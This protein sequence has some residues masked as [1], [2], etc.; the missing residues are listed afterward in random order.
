M[1]NCYVGDIGDFGKYGLLKALAGDDLRLGVAWYLNPDEAR[2]RSE[3]TLTGDG[4]LIKYLIDDKPNLRG[5]DPCLYDKLKNL[6]VDNCD[7]RVA[8]VRERHILS[9][10]TIFYER[11]L[12][13]TGLPAVGQRARQARLEHRSEWLEKALVKTEPCDLVFLDPDNGLGGKSA[14]PHTKAG[15]KFCFISEVGRWVERGQSV[16]VYHHADHQ[17]GGL[18]RLA[19][20]WSLILRQELEPQWVRTLAYHRQ[21]ARLYFILGRGA[22]HRRLQDRLDAFLETSWT[23]YG[24]FTEE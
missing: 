24:H 16:I 19:A 18:K 9:K 17:P 14:K 22:H 1:Q 13:F 11:P 2:K 5:C 8:A 3:E 4:S 23:T 21:S 15:Q 7:R 6:V 10:A 20:S 12:S